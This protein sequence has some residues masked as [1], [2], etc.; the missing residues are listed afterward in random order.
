MPLLNIA[1]VRLPK[2]DE[3]DANIVH[4]ICLINIEEAGCYFYGGG[5]ETPPTPPEKLYK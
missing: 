1:D 3:N 4:R 5:G 2:R